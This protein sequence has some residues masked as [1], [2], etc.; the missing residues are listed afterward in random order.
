MTRQSFL[1]FYPIR[2]YLSLYRS[3]ICIQ[4]H[5][6]SYYII[7]FYQHSFH[8]LLFDLINSK[9]HICIIKLFFCQSDLVPWTKRQHWQ[10]FSL[11]N[12]CG[13][14]ELSLVCDA[15]IDNTKAQPPNTATTSQNNMEM[16]QLLELLTL[17]CLY[18]AGFNLNMK[19]D[20][21]WQQQCAPH[22]LA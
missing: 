10:T 15:A 6:N 11:L 21:Y 4:K 9:Q 1:M 13:S 22:S 3:S 17:E 14:M 18:R 12:K 16:E 5:A 8:I 2:F 7:K 20:T 19:T